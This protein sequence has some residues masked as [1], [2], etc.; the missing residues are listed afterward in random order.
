MAVLLA[1]GG[2]SRLY[3]GAWGDAVKDTFKKMKRAAND[4]SDEY[5]ERKQKA[6]GEDFGTPAAGAFLVTL[7]L[8]RLP[9]RIRSLA[10][11]VLSGTFLMGFLKKKRKFAKK[12]HLTLD[13]ERGV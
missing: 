3:A 11:N 9:E 13:T 12:A 8:V 7:S 2:V 4:V 1:A 6:M 5:S 10:T